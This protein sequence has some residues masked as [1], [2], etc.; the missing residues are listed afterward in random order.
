MVYELIALSVGGTERPP[1]QH[2]VGHAG[3]SEQTRNPHRP[4][5]ADED[6]TLTFGQAKIGG[7]I[8]DTQACGSGKLFFLLWWGRGE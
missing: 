7:R 6:A 2:H 5:A 8:R 4:A 1:R 3:G